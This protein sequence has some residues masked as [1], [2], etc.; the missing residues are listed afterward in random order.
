MVNTS[1]KAEAAANTKETLKLKQSSI[2]ESDHSCNSNTQQDFQVNVLSKQSSKCGRLGGLS[3]LEQ[4]WACRA[5]GV[6][7]MCL[8]VQQLSQMLLPP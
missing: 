2:Q 1:T 6:N 3:E 7:Q 8:D 4:N 5:G